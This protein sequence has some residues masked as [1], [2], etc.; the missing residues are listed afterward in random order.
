M[1]IENLTPAVERILRLA[2]IEAGKDKSFVGVNHVLVGM[3]LEGDNYA[4][5]NLGAAGF[6]VEGLRKL[7]APNAGDERPS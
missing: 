3:M 6:T 1:Q 5:L 2:E 4:S 7:Q